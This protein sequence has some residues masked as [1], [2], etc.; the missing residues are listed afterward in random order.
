MPKA[1]DETLQRLR[2]CSR[3]LF[4]FLRIKCGGEDVPQNII[5][6]QVKAQS[7]ALKQYK[8][9]RSADWN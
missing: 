3:R 2:D 4:E 1:S 6:D 9:E 8:L 5:D 7:A